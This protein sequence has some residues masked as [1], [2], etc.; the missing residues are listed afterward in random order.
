MT[1]NAITNSQEG[2]I[3]QRKFSLV[4]ILITLVVIIVIGVFT[5][6]FVQMYTDMVRAQKKS[7]LHQLMTAINIFVLENKAA[8][9][10]VTDGW[11][12][13]GQIY[14]EGKCLGEL[15]AAGN[16]PRLFESPDKEPYYYYATK[17]YAIV[18]TRLNPPEDG[19]GKSVGK[20][21]RGDGDK[22]WCLEYKIEI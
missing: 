19:E 15:L 11:C 16:V 12:V 4:K 18:A 2:Y 6:Y 13:I 9:R 22:V 5:P 14:P 10:N 17:E 20:C 1:T 21:A 8:P 3:S 7:D